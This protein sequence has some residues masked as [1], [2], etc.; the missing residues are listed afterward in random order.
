MRPHGPLGAVLVLF[1]IVPATATEPVND[2]LLTLDLYL[3][4]EDVRDPQLSPTS[5]EIIY[6]R[7]W[8]DKMTDRWESSLWILNGDGTKHRFLIDGSSPRW[9]PDGTRIAFLADGEPGGKQ[10]F[11]RWMDSE[12]AVS[13]ITRLIE[14]PSD[15]AWSP[16]G[17]FLA[18]RMRV[19][20]EQ[21]TDALWEIDLPEPPEGA[22]WTEEPRIIE[23]IRH[24][25][26]RT[27]FLEE[28][29]Q[30]I[31]I[32]TA[33]G[34]TPR[35][36]TRG[37]FEHG[38]PQWMPDGRT[39][40]FDSMR[41]ENADYQWR[42]SEIYAVDKDSKQVRQLTDRRGPDRGPVVSPSGEHI[43]YTGYDETRDDYIDSSLY[44]MNRDGSNPRLLT[45]SLDRTP[46]ELHWAADGS[47]VYFSVESDGRMNLYFA[48]LAG[49][50]KQ[51]TQGMHFLTVTDM[52]ASGRA[53]GVLSSPNEPR[54]VVA[55]DVEAPGEIRQLTFVN[56]DVLAGVKLGEVEEIEYTSVGELRIQ[57]WI[58]KPPD[59]DA[60]RKY[61]MILAIHGGPHAM[62][63]VE[64]D[65][66]WQNQAANGYVVLYTNPR[67]SSGY[68]SAF[69]NAIQ[70]AY[71]GDDFHDLMAGVDTVIGR[72]YIDE[73]NLFVYGCSGGGVLTAWVVGHT[74]RFAAASSNCPVINWLSFVG[75][76]DGNPLRWY[77]DFEKLPW[78]DPSEHLRR[79]PL[80]SVGNV[81]TPT[82]LM[83]GVNDM[84][85]PISQTQEFYQALKVRKVPTAMIR[86]NDEWH[87][88]SSRPSN[89]M[90]TQLYLRKW[91]Q[92]FAT[93]GREPT[94][95]GSP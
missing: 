92:R 91:F 93:E 71:P 24:R 87:G 19:P 90:R 58:V 89:F 80:M 74:D 55:F 38:A 49:D 17:R 7:R 18:F 60:S 27:G 45:A 77:A 43:A 21:P 69:G 61:P 23:R 53:V 68:G 57:G 81:T 70:Y 78:E 85:T 32:V 20:P 4:W 30:Q 48:P 79:S 35:Q 46:E 40:V 34:G 50:A 83:T 88:T 16:D 25:Q 28:G 9:S 64:L 5:G 22:T 72:G 12:G 84:R 15:I 29:F 10:I 66:A 51:V 82:M 76:V 41:V 14:T 39:L 2:G 47:G 56:D 59:F 94:T 36:I 62:Y 3:E 6:T 86:M 11:V 95:S 65:F 52:N 1:L 73:R 8:V 67:G 26:D 54:D 37:D 13:Q 42:E 63:D 33:D 31:F 75:N 44:V